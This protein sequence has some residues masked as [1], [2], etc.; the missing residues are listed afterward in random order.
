MGGLAGLLGGAEEGEAS[1]SL[2]V[3][4]VAPAEARGRV[5]LLMQD[6]EAQVVLARVGDDVPRHG[7]CGC[8]PRGD[9]ASR[10]GV[11]ERGGLGRVP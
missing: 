11:P 10:G 3:D 5:G 4:G 2:T 9:L 8:S 6:P 1:G 7:E